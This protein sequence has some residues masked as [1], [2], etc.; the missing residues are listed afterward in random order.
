ME[1]NTCSVCLEAVS[2][3][4]ASTNNNNDQ[5]ED[6]HRPERLEPCNHI[7]HKDCIERWTNQ[8]NS[9]PQC[10]SM[11][12]E[13]VFVHVEGT[14]FSID[15][16]NSKFDSEPESEAEL[17][18]FGEY[19]DSDSGLEYNFPTTITNSDN[20]SELFG[21]LPDNYG[22][23][24]NNSENEIEYEQ[25]SPNSYDSSGQLKYYLTD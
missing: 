23:S 21:S 8:T 9:C 5:E 6:Q 3:N 19:S 20:E 15:G 22:T 2:S 17:A 24:S 25:F 18:S 16:S 13:I 1:K 12:D 14:S 4:R 7:Y 10:R 11:V